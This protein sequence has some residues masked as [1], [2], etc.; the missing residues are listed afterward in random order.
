MRK[1]NK[2]YQLLGIQSP[3]FPCSQPPQ[4]P[5]GRVLTRWYSGEIIWSLQQVPSKAAALSGISAGEKEN[6]SLSKESIHGSRAK[7]WVVPNLYVLCQPDMLSLQNKWTKGA[8]QAAQSFT[9]QMQGPGNQLCVH[10]RI[11]L[12]CNSPIRKNCTDSGKSESAWKRRK[13]LGFSESVK[14]YVSPH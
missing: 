3:S 1:P 12:A 2:F 11:F 5:S 8:T 9:K 14:S 13:N 7:P 4:V 10:Q 6:Q